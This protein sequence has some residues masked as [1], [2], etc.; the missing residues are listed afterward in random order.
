M[1]GI[2]SLEG[3]I[4]SSLLLGLRLGPLLVMAPPF[5]LARVPRLFAVLM[6][7]GLAAALVSGHPGALITDLSPGTLVLFAAR[8][9]LLGLSLATAFQIV[10]GA[11][12]MAGRTIDIQAGY[13]LALIIDPTTRTQTPLIG[14]LFAYA[15]AAVFFS[16]DGHL[17]LLRLLSIQLDVVPLGTWN[18]PHSIAPM[19]SFVSAV[20]VSALGVGAAAIV[21]LFLV[22]M[23]IALLSRTVPQMNALVMGFQVK[24]LVVLVVLPASF[25]LGG[26]VLLHLMTMTLQALPRIV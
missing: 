16:V 23:I 25:G 24:T 1:T 10:F 26:A 15:A 17:E 6:S 21:A 3:W 18:S 19:A 13:G 7:L 20:F 5:T 11:L 22:D 9:L 8:E 12:Y 14:T 2:R 4:V